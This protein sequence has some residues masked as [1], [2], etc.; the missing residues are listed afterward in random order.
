[1]FQIPKSANEWKSVAQTFEENWNFP[2][3]VGAL[4]GKHITIQAPI[5]SGSEFY[6]YKQNFSVVL[7]A[8][9]DAEY[10]FMFADCGS[11][12]RLSDGSLK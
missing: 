6:N 9:V 12:G 10:C 3:C 5:N 1:M 7:M 11:Q 4:D 8:L 2:H